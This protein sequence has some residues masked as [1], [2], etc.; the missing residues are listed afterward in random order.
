M[1]HFLD[2]KTDPGG[3]LA[4][5][6]RAA[7]IATGLPTTNVVLAGDWNEFEWEDNPCIK[8]FYPDDCR[9]Q[10]KKRMAALWDDYLWGR[11]VDVVVNHTLTCCTKW[12]P[13][14]RHTTTCRRQGL[15]P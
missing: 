11:A 10:A 13:A 4:Y 15:E 9:A 5:A 14:D 1:P 12:A 7:S 6:L 3:I 8:P 2:T